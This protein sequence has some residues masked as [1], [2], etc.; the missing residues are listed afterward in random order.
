MTTCPQR[1]G[2]EGNAGPSGDLEVLADL[3]RQRQ[4]GQ[5]LVPELPAHPPQLVADAGEVAQWLTGAGDVTVR[6]ASGT[7]PPDRPARTEG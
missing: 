6:S 3:Q 1:T 7:T 5:V 2:T 4:V